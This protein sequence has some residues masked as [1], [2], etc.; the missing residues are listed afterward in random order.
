MDLKIQFDAAAVLR[1]MERAPDSTVEE[2]R[3]AILESCRL[4]QQGAREKHKFRARTG[5]LERAIDYHVDISKCEG[6]IEI[7]SAVAPYG[8]WVHQGTSPHLIVPKNKQSLRWAGAGGKF[9]FAKK[10]HHPGTKK[11]EFLY[12]AAERS[13]IEINAI[14]ARHID[15]AT[16]EAGL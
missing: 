11:D 14:F 1:A 15:T 13:R 9:I 4:V 5:M 2:M 12:E 8:K 7:D 6:V 16:K 10:V 3:R